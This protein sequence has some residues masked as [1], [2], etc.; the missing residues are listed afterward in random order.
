M[1]R[2]LQKWKDLDIRHLAKITSE[3]RMFEGIGDQ[4]FK[5]EDLKRMLVEEEE[6]WRKKKKQ[7]VKN[8]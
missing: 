2:V 3:I 8:D 4:T 1:N 6:E 5:I 7:S